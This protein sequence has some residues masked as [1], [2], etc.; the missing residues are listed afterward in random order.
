[1]SLR[2]PNVKIFMSLRYPN[3]KIFMSPRYTNVKIFMSLRY[4]NVKMFMSLR[5][6]NVKYCHWAKGNS[7]FTY[8][9]YSNNWSLIYPLIFLLEK[10]LPNAT[11]IEPRHEKTCLCHMRTTKAQISLCVCLDSIIPLVSIT[12]I[13]SL[14]LASVAAQGSSSLPLSQTLKTSFLVTRLNLL[15]DTNMFFTF[16]QNV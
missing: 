5:Y 11:K 4:P 10:W 7:V 8:S 14:N 9:I 13:S 15:Y 16:T 2:Y 6:L 1:M 3:V 12:K